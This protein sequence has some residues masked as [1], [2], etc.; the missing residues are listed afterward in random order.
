VAWSIQT[1]DGQVKNGMVT[2][3]TPT[4]VTLIDSQAQKSTLS[5][6]KIERMEESPVSIMPENLLKSMSPQNLRDL[7]AYLQSKPK[8]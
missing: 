2:E 7:F 8:P 6:Q 1:T 4:M 5:R 3:Q